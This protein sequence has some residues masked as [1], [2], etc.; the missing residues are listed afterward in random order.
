MRA[1]HD[2]RGG[3][4]PPLKHW[5]VVLAAVGAVLLVVGVVWI[6]RAELP[7]ENFVINTGDCHIPVTLTDPAPDV[8]PAGSV[9]LIHGLSAN[10]KLMTYLAED[11]AGHGFRSFSIDLPGHGDNSDPFTVPRAQFCATMAVDW[12]TRQDKIDPAKTTI[13]G[14]SMGGA[15]AIRMADVEP[16][17]A[18]IAISPGPTAPQTR[19][20]ANLLVFSASADLAPLKRVAARLQEAA[21]G[22]RTAPDDFAQKRAFDLELLPHST[23][24]S[25]ITDRRV[26]HR[27]EQWM[28]QTVFSGSDANT[29]TLN[30]D[31]GTYESYGNGRRRLAGA[32]LGQIGIILIFPFA[33][34]VAGRV[35]GLALVEMPGTCPAPLLVILEMIVS[36]LVAILILRFGVPLRFLHIYSADY[37]V[38]LLTIAGLVLLTLNLGFLM[39]YAWFR[40]AK[41][42]AAGLLAFAT[43]I[44]MGA[45]M[46][47]QLTDGLPNTPRWFRFVGMLP[48]LYLYAFAEEV[49]LG[50][51][52]HGWPRAARFILFGAL[53]VEILLACVVGYYSLGNGQ[54]LLILLAVFFIVFSI[55]Q[56]LATDAVRAH[57]GS[58]T[59]A[60]LFGAIL[61]AWFVATIFPLT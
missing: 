32:I 47:W 37:L 24:T 55:L 25:L 46:N 31:L 16:V 28:M 27:S 49:V 57:T 2:F 4:R 54:I 56:R 51:V 8:S 34:F 12:L 44:A 11:F 19:M 29:V 50:P 13:V 45:W 23:H 36:V 22:D 14:H 59:A 61:A 26:A 48:F 60:A 39:E 43:I 21:Q 7:H 40:S 58:A 6:R 35:S 33:A 30:L 52:K 53:R 20:P 17:A 5:R 38:S 1:A 18:T 41:L 15:I 9:V 10:R 42:L 3:A